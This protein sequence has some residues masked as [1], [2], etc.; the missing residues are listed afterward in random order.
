MYIDSWRWY[1]D[2]QWQAIREGNREHMRLPQ[3]YQ[4]GWQYLEAAQYDQSIGIFKQGIELAREMQLPMWEFFFESWVCEL[5]VLAANYK[6]ALDWTTRLVSKSTRPE[7]EDHPCRAVVYFSLAWVYFYLDAIGYETEILQALDA[8]ENDMP[9]DEETHHRSIFVRAELA[10]EK[11]NYAQALAISD[12][13]MNLVDGN[14]FRETSGYGMQR[15]VA[16]AQGDIQTALRAVGLR[17]QSSR[18]ANLLNNAANSVLWEAVLCQYDGQADKAETLIKR[19]MDEYTA[20]SL[21][22]QSSYYHILAEYETAR[23][24]YSTALEYRD[25]QLLLAIAS[26]SLSTEFYCRLDRC[27]LLNRIG[28][29]ATD[30][31]Q[32][33]EATAKRCRKPDFFL[34]KIAA[35][36][37]GQKTRYAWQASYK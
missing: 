25:Q 30:A 35:V 37:A 5:N 34:A 24:N 7:Y 12:R 9:L 3:L 29:D 21:P 19:G 36:R 14:P 18:D 23:G 6:E 20:L 16:Y 1:Q 15:A 26:G 31:L 32:A 2:F 17:E 10:Y 27:L 4:T 28:Q 8:L 33:T 22:I 13:Y 11:E